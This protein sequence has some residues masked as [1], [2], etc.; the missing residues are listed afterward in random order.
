MQLEAK[1]GA[2]KHM[3]SMNVWV[4]DCDDC[5]IVVAFHFRHHVA[6]AKAAAKYYTSQLSNQKNRTST[7]VDTSGLPDVS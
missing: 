6:M 1:V 7:Y 4:L 3:L 2:P 5:C